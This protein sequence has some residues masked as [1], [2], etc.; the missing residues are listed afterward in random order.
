AEECAKAT[1]PAL[2]APVRE[3]IMPQVRGTQSGYLNLLNPRG[4]KLPPIRL[5]QI[6]M[7]S[8][9]ILSTQPGFR[10]S[11]ERLPERLGHVRPNAIAT[12]P[13]SRPNPGQHITRLRP[14]RFTHRRNRR[15]R[16]ASECPTPAR[17]GQAEC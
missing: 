9:A 13:D 5:P 14:E 2:I 15:P 4:G 7:F 10:F 16:R 8:Y 6:E 12:R 1:R 11:A 17:V 3:E